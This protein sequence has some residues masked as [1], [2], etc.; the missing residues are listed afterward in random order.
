MLNALSEIPNASFLTLKIRLVT[1]LLP[2]FTNT[3]EILKVGNT[4]TFFIWYQGQN[5]YHL[6][7]KTLPFYFKSTTTLLLIK[8]FLAR[9]YLTTNNALLFQKERY[10]TRSIS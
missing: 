6:D 3:N 4:P 9:I 8:T 10:L 1:W 7:R 2:L 5:C